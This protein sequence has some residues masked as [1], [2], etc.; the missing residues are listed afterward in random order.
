MVKPFMNPNLATSLNMG[1]A[2][3]TPKSKSVPSMGAGLAPDYSSPAVSDIVTPQKTQERRELFINSVHKVA[4]ANGV[5]QDD[6]LTSSLNVIDSCL[7]CIL[8]IAAGNDLTGSRQARV[9]LNRFFFSSWVFYT[10]FIVVFL[11][12]G[13]GI[14]AYRVSSMMVCDGQ[15]S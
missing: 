11:L 14:L 3:A 10:G 6:S 12:D 4:L 2:P 8:S 9:K 5:F 7:E 13:V 1:L 15:I